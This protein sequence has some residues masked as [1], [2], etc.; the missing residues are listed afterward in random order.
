M[1]LVLDEVVGSLK[2]N[3]DIFILSFDQVVCLVQIVDVELTFHVSGQYTL[4][5]VEDLH[6]FITALRKTLR[7]GLLKGAGACSYTLVDA[8]VAISFGE[9]QQLESLEILWQHRFL[10]NLTIL[11]ISNDWLNNIEGFQAVV[12]LKSIAEVPDR[13]D[14]GV[15]P[16]LVFGTAPPTFREVLGE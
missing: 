12:E 1:F 6:D 9:F 4:W 13:H 5:W 16:F 11:I 3:H 8:F 15:Y 14:V 10:C 7:K 2:L